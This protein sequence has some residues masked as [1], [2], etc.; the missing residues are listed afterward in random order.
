[1]AAYFKRCPHCDRLIN[2][3]AFNRHVELCAKCDPAELADMLEQ[4]Y[5]KNAIAKHMGISRGFVGDRTRM[6]GLS[7]NPNVPMIHDY[8]PIERRDLH[9][10]LAPA[11]GI[12]RS[13]N[14]RCPHWETCTTLMRLSPYAWAMCERPASNMVQAI[15]DQ[16][17]IL[18]IYRT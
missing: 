2:K 10:N 4:G 18:E 5:T 3:G 9:P 13:C 8:T 1:M 12:R 7:R 16:P 17:Y 14:E 11:F 15:S 6:L